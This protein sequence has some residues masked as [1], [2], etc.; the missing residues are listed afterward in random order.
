M[1]APDLWALLLA[2]SLALGTQW[3]LPLAELWPR[4]SL[5][6]PTKALN[7]TIKPQAFCGTSKDSKQYLRLSYRNRRSLTQRRKSQTIYE[8]QDEAL[9]CAKTFRDPCELGGKPKVKMRNLSLCYL[10]TSTVD[11]A[12]EPPLL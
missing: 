11:T 8:R 5:V 2:T 6:H 9:S 7:C 12:V 3:K 10:T 1:R 4:S